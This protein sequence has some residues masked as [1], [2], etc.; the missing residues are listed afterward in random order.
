MRQTRA[1]LLAEALANVAIGY[2]AAVLTQMLVLPL[3]GL[4]GSLRDRTC[5]SEQPS[6]IGR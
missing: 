2:G 6:M 4:E 1:M 5:R 3:F